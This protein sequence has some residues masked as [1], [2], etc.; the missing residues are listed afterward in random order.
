[1]RRIGVRVAVI[2][3]VVGCTALAAIVVHASWERA[4]A[5]NVRALV[6]QLNGQVAASVAQELA[7]VLENAAA[8]REALRSIF[9]QG[10][11]E[12]TDEAKREFLFLALLQSQPSLS[13]IAFGWPDGNFFGAQKVGEREIRMV[14]VRKIGDG[15]LAERR[16]DT[17]DVD[18]SDI[19]FTGRDLADTTY[20]VTD[21]PWY[22]MAA[23]GDGPVWGEAA[24]FPTRV[25][26]AIATA[27]PLYVYRRFV[28][29][30]NVTIE[31]ERLSQ[32]LTGLKV[33]LTGAAYIL[34][35][36]GRV[37]AAPIDPMARPLPEDALPPWRTLQG[38]DDPLLGAVAASLAQAGLALDTIVEPRR[39]E[40]STAG[41]RRFFVGLAPLPFEHWVVATVV[42]AED[43]VGDIE[44]STRDLAWLLVGLVLAIAVAA[45]WAADRLL[46][47]PL[48]RIAG[49]LRHIEQF[50]LDRLTGVS[51]PLRELDEL[52]LAL[53]QMAGGLAS[54]QK[55]LPTDLVRRLVA[56]GVAARA[57][58][59]RA[60]LTVM[61]T[62]LAGFT[63]LSERLGEGVVPILSAH[64]GDV[65]AA[66]HAAGG[67]VDKFIGD[68]VMAFWNAPE[69]VA[70]HAVAACRAALAA[71]ASLRG[72]EHGL[73][74]RVG[75]NTGVVLV[76]NIGAEDRLN[77]TAVGDAVNVAS[78]LESLNKIY[79]TE[80]IL[81]EAARQAAGDAIVVRQLDVVAVYG[82]QESI[83][84]Y[85]LLALA[86]GSA[87]AGAFD[88][89]A[90]YEAGLDSYRACDWSMAIGLFEATIAARGHDPASETMIARCRGFIESPPA[91]D[92]RG[93][94]VAQAK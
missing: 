45:T 91:A 83:E 52:S 6:D 85:E 73:A 36:D 17:Y 72:R 61:F 5:R 32:F 89:V 68:A 31:L 13:W 78:R 9:Y 65:S 94:L 92:W 86:D 23:A 63:R 38:D 12:T 75:I 21:Q 59:S 57:G 71:Q 7:A 77:Y 15:P 66:V 24:A 41:G 51:S 2:A 93:I 88:W 48:G 49:Q 74:M 11:I 18:A 90:T 67:T 58:G 26:P 4:A 46:S 30:L 19:M 1:V 33:G 22:T 70:G 34:S 29:V 25:R 55:F 50:R 35:P 82:R 3:L 14:E 80:V 47:R 84:I 28:G 40:V 8:A 81:G 27:V 69:P 87:P 10:M 76:G 60:E 37:L 43:F 42:P 20:R 79:G 16:V 62:D 53:R 56:S 44:R 64:L 39:I 54:F